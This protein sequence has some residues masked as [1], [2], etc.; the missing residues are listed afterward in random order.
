[1]KILLVGNPNVGKSAIFSRLTGTRIITSNY[2]GTTVEYTR[3]FLKRS[4]DHD[5]IID[6]PGIYS[7]EPSSAADRVAIDML[8]EG[9]VIVNVVDATNLERNLNLTLQL[10]ERQV[11]MIVALNM[12]DD[13][14]HRGVSIDVSRLEEVL[15]V[16]VVPTVGV[17]S[18]GIRQ[19][20]DRLPEA[21]VPPNRTGDS[22][23]RWKNIGE[24]IGQTQTLTHRHHT[25]ADIMEDISNHPIGGFF[26]AAVVLLAAFWIIRFIGE[27]IINYIAGPLFDWAWTPLLERL[28]ALLGP[29]NFIHNIFIGNLIDGQIDY[30]QSFGLLS[31]GLYIPFAAV[32][33]YIIAFYFILG[34][35]EDVGYL[36]RLAVLMDTIL[37]R[38]GLHGY[39]IIPTILG[40]GCNVPAIMATRILES[41]R[42]RF[43]AA[44]L[45]CIAIPCAALQ[46]MVIGLVGEHGIQY[47]AMVYG[48]LFIAWLVIGFILNTL[49]KGFSPELVIELPP[50]RMPPWRIIAEKLWMRILGFIKEALPIVLGAVFVIN[51]LYTFGVFNFIASVTAPVISGLFGLPK[52]TV[53]AI[54]LGFL[55][56]DVAMGML[57][58]LSLTPEQLV[59]SSTVL[60]MSFPCVA[61]FVVLARELGVIDMLKATAIMLITALIAGTLLNLI[62][63]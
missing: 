35:L 36:P 58:P 24:I 32:L 31:T 7:L 56:K 55:R 48:T 19:L 57:A 21:Q 11:P 33:P 14:R 62:L 25:F 16:P 23:E 4:Q 20:V 59:I 9:D 1:M 8:S 12:W 27:G 61:T 40:L 30:F 39:A 53:I 45:I 43:I 10:M 5:E 54:V 50:Y 47:V 38:L 46:A 2:P 60:A 13:V 41:K 17:T 37:H 3:G 26:V 15:G 6:V 42:E 18:E 22:E 28:S 29:G 49:V 51:I 52:E 44:T 34:L 63:Q